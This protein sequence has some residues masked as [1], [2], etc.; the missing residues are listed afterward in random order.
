[1]DI[2]V[3]STSHPVYSEIFK[4]LC[5]TE[6][7]VLSRFWEEVDTQLLT[8]VTASNRQITAIKFFSYIVSHLEESSQV[9]SLCDIVSIFIKLEF[10]NNKY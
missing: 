6:E 3:N 5:R 8:N 9:L 1:M 7:E 4:Y 2:K 10:K